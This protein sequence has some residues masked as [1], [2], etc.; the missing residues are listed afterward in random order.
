MQTPNRRTLHFWLISLLVAFVA[1][2]FATS[3]GF[4]APAPPPGPDRYKVTLVK[5][6]AYEWYMA[7]FKLNQI[8]CKI[9]VDYEGT[10][11]LEDIYIDCGDELTDQWVA[12]EPC[13][14]PKANKCDG[15][16]IFPTGSYPAEKEVAMELPAPAVWL[17]VIDCSAVSSQSTSVCEYIPK[18]VLTA[19]EPLPEQYITR[20]EGRL[21]GQSFSCEGDT[22]IIGLQ[23]TDEKGVL[24]EFWAYSTMATAV[25]DSPHRCASPR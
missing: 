24:L 15:Y 7:T 4:A 12:Q 23:P 13:L 6:T 5:Y 10:P 16:Y 14:K 2:L 22:C 25:K 19:Q 18:L 17:D 11:T 9:V 8:V 21:N 1:L 3:A 20:V